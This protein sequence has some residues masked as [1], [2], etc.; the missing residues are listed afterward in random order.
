[1]EQFRNDSQEI[2]MEFLSAQFNTSSSP[3]NLVLQSPASVQ[4]GFDAAS[5][6]NFNVFPL[7]F[8]PDQ[9]F[10][11]Y[12]FDW[13]PGRVSFY[14]DG[15]WLRDMTLDAPD[16]PGKLILN[17]WSNGDPR[18]S[19]GPPQQDALLTV[20]YVKAYFNSSDPERQKVY[21]RACNGNSSADAVC[22]IP[23]QLVAPD[24]N[25]VN[26]NSTAHTYFFTNEPGQAENQIVY[27]T[28]HSAASYLTVGNQTL[29]WLL[30]AACSAFSLNG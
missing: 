17:H 12:R 28:S 7:P 27:T 9:S 22:Q 6:P 26:G 5:T 11:E 16:A 10:H 8:R 21:E 1:L 4:A 18:W 14:A 23:D 3:V 25:G 24:P 20:S 15:Q 2:D 30:L 19:A 29:L 13:L